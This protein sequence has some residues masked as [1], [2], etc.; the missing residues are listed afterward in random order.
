MKNNN[1]KKKRSIT[2]LKKTMNYEEFN[3]FCGLLAKQYA[4]SETQFARTYFCE[5]YN[6]SKN[7]YYKILEYAI[8]TNLVSDK[9]VSRMMNKAIA[10]AEA[11]AIGGGNAVNIHYNKML[12][13]RNNYIL[14]QIPEQTI[15]NFANDFADNPDISK[16]DL[17]EAYEISLKIAELILVKAIEENIVP[18]HV[19]D[20]I[21]S[22][23]IINA[24][25]EDLQL[26]KN[27][28]KALRQKRDANL[29]GI[30]LN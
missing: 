15:V 6:I 2:Q 5:R 1:K 7:C 20:S 18:D 22:R 12:A 13:Q 30:T 26:T 24:D 28:F 29:K 23:S 9:V 8:V 14:L 11:H 4:N 16:Y 21:E 10:N 3:V 25:K 17:A 27:F 19:V